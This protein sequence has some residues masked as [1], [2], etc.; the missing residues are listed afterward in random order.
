MI[1][2][3]DRYLART[4]F[5]SWAASVSFF[6]GMYL[7]IHFFSDLD[8]LGDRAA[9][10]HRMGWS[11]VGGL[12]RYYGL[13][14]PF[15]LVMTAP[16]SILMGAMWTGQ[17]LARKNELVAILCAGVSLRRVVLAI[18]FLGSLVAGGFSLLREAWLPEIA[19]ERH[20]IERIFKGRSDDVLSD[21]PLVHD[22]RGLAFHV[23]RYDVLDRVADGVTVF[24][25]VGTGE[26]LLEVERMVWR[27]GRWVVPDGA[28]VDG[29]RARLERT[30]LGPRDFEIEDRGLLFL[31]TSELRA[32]RS[33]HPDRAALEVALHANFAY[34]I[35]C[36]VLML[37]GLPLV[38]RAERRTP[39]LAAGIGLLLSVA[40]F[41]VERVLLDLG[42][43]EELF[44]PALGA[45]LPVILFGAIG[46]LL[47]E[48]MRT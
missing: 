18:V 34:P 39:F 48:T 29:P 14:L 12:A 26:E 40:Y 17:Q 32:L 21:L 41:A 33:R 19:A 1:K 43:R 38:L 23:A 30:D 11:T 9:S 45:W 15:V 46:L 13:Q 31:S 27:K 25:P 4:F 6:A 24:P 10:F 20:R 8:D 22:G 16:F 28:R 3:L 36:I 2:R 7:V 37:M 5:W 47:V 35:G 44:A 42:T